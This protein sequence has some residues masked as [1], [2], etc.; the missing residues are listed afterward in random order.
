[1]EFD[2]GPKVRELGNWDGA[3][4]VSRSRHEK[5]LIKKVSDKLFFD[6]G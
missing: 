4:K 1:M 6:S 3:M 2:L 5:M